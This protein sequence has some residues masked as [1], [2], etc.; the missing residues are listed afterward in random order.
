MNGQ[1]SGPVSSQQLFEIMQALEA[2]E[3]R[4]KGMQ[5]VRKCLREMEA[6]LLVQEDSILIV[7]ALP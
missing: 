7:G 1:E 6:P 2:L 4:V 5:Q 3:T